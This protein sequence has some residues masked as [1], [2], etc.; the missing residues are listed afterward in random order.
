M[1]IKNNQ[2]FIDKITSIRRI[3]VS[4]IRDSKMKELEHDKQN[5][6]REMIQ[7]RLLIPSIVNKQIAY[8]E[9]Q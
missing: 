3:A 8:V 1:E 9:F 5:Q 2:Y 6:E 7:R 4:N